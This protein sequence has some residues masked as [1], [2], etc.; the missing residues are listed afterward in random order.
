L[1]DTNGGADATARSV[2]DATGEIVYRVLA[3][4]L[5]IV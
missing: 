5:G 1:I 2:L 3:L 4:L